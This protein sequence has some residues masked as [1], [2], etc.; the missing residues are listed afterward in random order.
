MK[1]TFE[2]APHYR[3]PQSTG[4]IMKELTLCLCAVTLFA[5]IYYTMAFGA[6]YG[7]RVV[8]MMVLAVCAGCA[9]EAVYY[10]ATK[11]D[12][13]KGILSSYPWVTAMILTLIS[14]IDN[15][16]YAIVV[17]VVIAIIFGKLVFGGFGQNIFNPAAF[18][19]AILMNSFAA[20]KSADFATGAT[21]TQAMNTYGWMLS[22]ENFNAMVDKYGGL[23]RMLLGQYP[24]TIGSTCAILILICGIVMI[25]RKDID[26]QAPVFYIGTIFVVSLLIGLMHGAGVWYAVFQVLAGGVMFGGVFMMTDPVTLPVTIPGRVIFAVGAACFTLIFRLRSNMADGVLYSILLMNMLT[27]AIDKLMDGNQIKNA[28][29]N[30]RTV[31]IA[32]AVMLAITL[33]IGFI[34]EGKLPAGA[35]VEKASETMTAETAAVVPDVL[36]ADSAA[37]N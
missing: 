22:A 26:W 10:K 3:S 8:I 15:S 31:L 29:K 5:V 16:Y 37:G 11:Q 35:A 1:L 23:G 32:C 2:P 34:A 9:T 25:I 36:Y 21:P 14:S 20:A 27:P 24:S 28:A 12:I 4:G 7:L 6:S 19:E 13:K 33:G 30:A 18:G 17:S